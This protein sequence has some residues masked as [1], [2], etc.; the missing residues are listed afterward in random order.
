MDQAALLELAERLAWEA[1]ETILALRLRGFSTTLKPDH[2]AVTD[3]DRAAEAVILRGLRAATPAIAVAAEE[4]IAA[5]DVPAPADM[6]WLVDPLDGTRDFAA[7]RDCFAINIGLV[8]HGRPVLGVVCEPA[9]ARLYGG[10]VGQFAYV[11][12]SAGR[13]PIRARPCPARG[14][15]LLTA[16]ETLDHPAITAA[17]A[18]KSISS[19]EQLG[20]SLKFCRI[21]EGQ[22]DLYARQGR[23]MEWDTAA[24]EAVLLAAGGALADL[25]GIALRY[26]KPGFANPS[27]IARGAA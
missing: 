18:G 26:G 20:S 10:I 13:R 24:P 16:R 5:G 7:E 6:L 14:A 27:F 3:A 17:L 22:A 15:H 19:R 11:Q 9:A 25:H 2:S 23:S 1:A 8:R 4:A 21:A 12:D